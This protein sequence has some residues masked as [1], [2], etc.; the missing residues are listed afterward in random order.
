[1]DKLAH[2]GL[3]GGQVAV[4]LQPHAALGL[5]AALLH[6]LLDALI[7]G[8]I[9]LL[10]E[11]VQHR[12]A[13]HETVVGEFLHEL[14]DGGEAA[15]HL[16]PGL[17]HSPPPGHVDVG[18]ADA[19]GHDPVPAAHLFVE[20]FRDI[21]LGLPQGGVKALG[22]GLPQIQKIDGVVQN[23]LDGQPVLAVLLHPGEGP[24][25]NLDIPVEPVDRLV[26]L[27]ELH[28]ELEF[29]V[30]RAGIRLNIHL[31]RFPGGGLG[32]ELHLP[33]V[34]VQ[35]L[36]LPAVEEEE[37]LGV[38]PVVPLLDLGAHL[39]PDALAR[40]VLGNGQLTPE[41]IV[42]VRAVPVHGFPVESLPGASLAL[43]LGGI[44]EKALFVLPVRD[45]PDAADAQLAEIVAD[46]LDPL[47]NEIH[48]LVA[49]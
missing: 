32:E 6:P 21:R 47:V 10:E 12:L 20:I 43:R 4:G 45:G 22:V 8:G 46:H 44:E 37:E 35:S 11:V 17:G 28:Q 42:L 1:M 48:S 3:A 30:K 49:P 40:Q 36:G 34:H 7:E 39:H 25:R 38:L 24:E 18:V 13:G 16:L 14:E 27:V 31:E 9:A 5:P 26:L 33:V 19:G 15:G 29:G 23:R 41:P 2:Q